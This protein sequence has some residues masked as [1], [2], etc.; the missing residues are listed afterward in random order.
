MHSPANYISPVL[1]VDDDPRILSCLKVILHHA[2]IK[3]II[4]ADD[5]RQVL[6]I[7]AKQD[8]AVIVLELPMPYLPGLEILKVSLKLVDAK[9]KDSE[10]IDR[11]NWKVRKLFEKELDQLKQEIKEL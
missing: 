8:V 10:Q 1:I 6:P 3:E 2:G 4:T 11:S 5:S 9:I 7:L